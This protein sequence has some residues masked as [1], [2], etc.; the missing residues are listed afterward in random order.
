M[1][2]LCQILSLL[3]MAII[4]FV[5]GACVPQ[6]INISIIPTESV[7]NTHTSLQ[8]EYLSGDYNAVNSFANGTRELSF[9][10]AITLKWSSGENRVKGVVYTVE[11]SQNQDFSNA[12]VLKTANNFVDV[13][14]LYLNTQYY[15]RVSAQFN[16]NVIAGNQTG[17]F[18]TSAT[19][20]RNIFVDGITNVRDLGGWPTAN[21]GVVK[22]GLLYR[23]GRINTSWYADVS[24]DITPYGI[25]TM[26]ETLG[27]K[28]EIDLR[29]DYQNEV[30][31]LRE[32]VLGKDV[33][34]YACAM[35][36]DPNAL[37][38]NSIEG[39]KTILK[40]IFS[41]LADRANYPLFFHCDIGTDR[42]G[43]IAYLVNG[44]LGVEEDNL[45][46]DYLFSNFARI[47]GSRNAD[48][49]Q[50]AY[51][52]LIK[53]YTGNTLSEKIENVLKNIV[54]VSSQEINSIRNILL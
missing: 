47:G 31:L 2:K 45:Y 24:A 20:P 49:I 35:E 48:G 8:T 43:L 44:L 19:A 53:N 21:G 38:T 34:Y 13:Y 23:T 12:I 46:R 15:W 17:T 51:V 36:F 40:T 1:K 7:L 37:G 16:G 29:K 39:N 25:K 9:P 11:I 14:N 26:R 22:Q 27:I 52:E 30:S 41:L 3:C 50:S 6:S 33:N 10:Q 28:S 5:F 42:T 18:K 54:G 32:S 4:V